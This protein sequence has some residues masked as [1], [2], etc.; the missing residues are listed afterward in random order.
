MSIG[1]T[2]ISPSFKVPR[3][4]AKILLAAGAVSSA[5]QRLKCLLVGKKTTAGSIVPD[6]PP[7]RVTDVDRLDVL[8]GAGSRL[9]L[10]GYAALT[11]PSIELWIAAVRERGASTAAP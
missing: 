8:A 3:Y 7:V 5:S 4:L 9:A 6:G 10:M 11:V 1:N 2:G